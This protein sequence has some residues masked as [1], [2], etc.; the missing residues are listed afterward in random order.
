MRFDNYLPRVLVALHGKTATAESASSAPP[1]H[2]FK[3]MLL[4]AMRAQD[5]RPHTTHASHDP[6]PW[7]LVLGASS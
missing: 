4:E 7:Y 3:H 5:T 1:R 2:Y 6:L